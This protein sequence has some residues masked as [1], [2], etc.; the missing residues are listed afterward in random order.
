M[1]YVE[2]VEIRRAGAWVVGSLLERGEDEITV[3]IESFENSVKAKPKDFADFRTYTSAK[4][5][6]EQ[7][8]NTVNFMDVKQVSNTISWFLEQDQVNLRSFDQWARGKIYYCLIQLMNLNYFSDPNLLSQTEPALYNIFDFYLRLLSS[9]LRVVNEL[10]NSEEFAYSVAFPEIKSVLLVFMGFEEPG[11]SFFSDNKNYLQLYHTSN[12]QMPLSQFAAFKIL[13]EC[14][15]IFKF[16]CSSDDLLPFLAIVVECCKIVELKSAVREEEFYSRISS[17]L[18]LTLNNPKFNLNNKDFSQIFWIMKYFGL[19]NIEICEIFVGFV[20]KNISITQKMQIFSSL[21]G[22]GNNDFEQVIEHIYNTKTYLKTLENE[23][24]L[25]YTVKYI[26]LLGSIKGTIE[27]LKE[28]LEH[29]KENEVLIAFIRV[30]SDNLQIFHSQECLIILKFL[31]GKYLFD[32]RPALTSLIFNLILNY[33]DQERYRVYYQ[34]ISDFPRAEAIMILKAVFS[35]LNNKEIFNDFIQKILRTLDSDISNE[36]LLN[37]IDTKEFILSCS[38]CKRIFNQICSLIETSSKTLTLLKCLLKFDFGAKKTKNYQKKIE[39][40]AFILFHKCLA[41]EIMM[42]L[43]LKVACQLSDTEKLSELFL[44]CYK[45]L[46]ENQRM[47]ESEERIFLVLFLKLSSQSLMFPAK[48]WEN[49]KFAGYVFRLNEKNLKFEGYLLGLFFNGKLTND[50]KIEFEKLIL[51][52]NLKFRVDEE[53]TKQIRRNFINKFI[54]YPDTTNKFELYY[55]MCEDNPKI[56]SD[57]T[58]GQMLKK[59]YE[60]RELELSNKDLLFYRK[61]LYST[62]KNKLPLND[63][64]Q[65]I[66]SYSDHIFNLILIE[67]IFDVIELQPSFSLIL[68]QKEFNPLFSQVIFYILSKKKE[69]K[70]EGCFIP[71]FWFKNFLKPNMSLYTKK[72]K[73]EC[74]EEF[75]KRINEF[76]AN[77][78]LELYHECLVSIFEQNSFDHYTLI[79]SFMEYKSTKCFELLMIN[80]LHSYCNNNELSMKKISNE[81][82]KVFYEL[83]THD[84]KLK[85]YEEFMITH[86]NPYDTDMQILGNKIK[87]LI[88]IKKKQSELGIKTNSFGPT[89]KKI[90]EFL[91]DFKDFYPK[92]CETALKEQSMILFTYYP[93]C[94]DL[95]ASNFFS[96]HKNCINS[97]SK[98]PKLS[99]VPMEFPK[100][101]LNFGSTCYVNSI[102]QLIFEINPICNQ[103]LNY[104][105]TNNSLNALKHILQ[106]LKFSVKPL[107]KSKILLKF[108][109]LY[110]G[111]FIDKAVQSDAEEFLNTIFCKL[112]LEKWNLKQSIEFSTSTILRCECNHT[113]KKSDLSYVLHLEVSGVE[114]I[115][116]SIEKHS[117]IQKLDDNNALICESCFEKSIKQMKNVIEYWPDYLICVFKR[118]RFNLEL[119][120]T[121]KLMDEVTLKNVI[122]NDKYEFELS[123]IISHMG[124]AEFGHYITFKK[125]DNIWYKIDDSNV[126]IIHD[127]DPEKTKF[128]EKTSSNNAG[129]T[130]YLVLYKKIIKNEKKIEN[131]QIDEKIVKKNIEYCNAS[132][133]FG[134]PII[135]FLSNMINA[136]VNFC[137]YLLVHSLPIHDIDP[138]ILFYKIFKK[139]SEELE[140]QDLRYRF[141]Y[142]LKMGHGEGIIKVLAGGAS[143]NYKLVFKSLLKK[144]F[145]DNS[146]G[147]FDILFKILGNDHM[148]HDFTVIINLILEI[149]PSIENQNYYIEYLMYYFFNRRYEN[150]PQLNLNRAGIQFTNFAS[151]FKYI[152]SKDISSLYEIFKLEFFSYLVALYCFQ[153]TPKPYSKLMAKTV[154]EQNV[155]NDYF[156]FIINSSINLQLKQR[157]VYDY[158]EEKKED[159]KIL[160]SE[161]FKLLISHI[162]NIELGVNSLVKII[163]ALS[164]KGEETKSNTCMIFHYFLLANNSKILPGEISFRFSEDNKEILSSVFKEVFTLGKVFDK[165]NKS[166]LALNHF[167]EKIEVDYCESISLVQIQDS[168]KL[169]SK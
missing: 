48:F 37:L 150:Y 17:Y 139:F 13:Q 82:E 131:I 137:I 27:L 38:K 78:K 65:Y 130:P 98:L 26:R 91:I 71:I 36:I 54:T 134:E 74:F 140:N 167:T 53:W 1:D 159:F 69:L 58:V 12:E 70:L 19:K 83:L 61:V 107:I 34:L 88:C 112:E 156:G 100:A 164:R 168:L 147:L 77:I 126:S 49:N 75:F 154:V 11:T 85:D 149:L 3:N 157:L 115:E 6:S 67:Q 119:G 64:L 95:I 96:F 146:L 148:A 122:V 135:H 45:D 125:L 160:E 46:Q 101:I 106:R 50:S 25:K 56:E 52:I 163:K 109:E 136:D 7:I 44:I 102:M 111:C 79:D 29:I 14:L 113:Y 51:A 165:K 117:S 15:N 57:I 94:R 81:A 162:L 84:N 104:E 16:E 62:Q 63:I 141:A 93:E 24:L 32:F 47:W 90:L 114:T 73:K 151:Y 2:L 89:L 8:L 155:H 39:S 97:Q 138:I 10:N 129:F 20:Q 30:I 161:E 123:L 124:Q 116:K 23:S 43:Y 21:D 35:L 166:K 68:S 108:Y 22:I 128:F 18:K 133:Y 169:V 40:I 121:E 59:R 132:I 105:G 28:I 92:I 80:F 152:Y 55:K 86:L 76:E 158:I 5:G 127:F 42:N 87:L 66:R 33:S 41:E 118:L 145:I 142:E 153:S 31:A 110:E 60:T 120:K 143:E 72:E 9:G 99:L 4:K 103:L 144:A